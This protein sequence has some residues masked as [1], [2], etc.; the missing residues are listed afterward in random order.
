[1]RKW[2]YIVLLVVTLGT[3]YPMCATAFAW[4]VNPWDLLFVAAEVAFLVSVVLVLVE[5]RRG[6]KWVAAVS[7]SAALWFAVNFVRYVLDGAAAIEL[8]CT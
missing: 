2:P 7:I 1:M 8:L 4:A 6:V 3:M 5:A